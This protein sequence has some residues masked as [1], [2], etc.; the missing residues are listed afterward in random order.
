MPEKKIIFRSIQITDRSTQFRIQITPFAFMSAICWSSGLQDILIHIR[1]LICLTA[2]GPP[3]SL[4]HG[5]SKQI[6]CF[7]L[8]ICLSNDDVWPLC[9]SCFFVS[10]RALFAHFSGGFFPL[11]STNVESSRN[12][13]FLYRIFFVSVCL[14]LWYS[15]CVWSHSQSLSYRNIY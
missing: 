15:R 11:L 7:V 2:L 5:S 10:F 1:K 12:R 9:Y 4:R 3:P 8:F 13:S 6:N 14:L